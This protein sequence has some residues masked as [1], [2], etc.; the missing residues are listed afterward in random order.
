[1]KQ[2][3]RSR[4]CVK[5]ETVMWETKKNA[6]LNSASLWK[7]MGWF[8]SLGSLGAK[9]VFHFYSF[10]FGL[11]HML[12][13]LNLPCREMSSKSTIS[14]CL[15]LLLKNETQ[16]GAKFTKQVT[17]TMTEATC[18]SIEL[19]LRLHRLTL[20]RTR[21][22]GNFGGNCYVTDVYWNRVRDWICAISLASYFLSLCLGCMKL[23][24]LNLFNS[25]NG[26]ISV[27]FQ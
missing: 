23:C 18:L 17:L 1:M 3:P 9:D 24:L 20:L 6:V 5:N 7:H 10:A 12:K 22:T 16:I 13:C 8:S 19:H 26:L 4:T 27:N 25:F 11:L 15:C 21:S 14:F 2:F